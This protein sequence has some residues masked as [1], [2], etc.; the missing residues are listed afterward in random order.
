MTQPHQ[1]LC[2][3]A[4]TCFI[5]TVHEASALRRVMK[6]K[7]IK[8]GETHCFALLRLCFNRIRALWYPGGY[9]P[10]KDH[11]HMVPGFRYPTP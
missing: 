9:P 8:V 5:G 1:G 6:Q 4:F 3:L 7:G 2:P 10:T 11:P